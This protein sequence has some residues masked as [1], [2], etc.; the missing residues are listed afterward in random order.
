[1]VT[2][3]ISRR[4]ALKRVGFLMGGAL[5]APAV[6]GFLGGCRTGAEAEW[7][8]AVLTGRH[9]DLTAAVADRIIPETDTPGAGH[10]EVQQFIDRML[11][12]WYPDDLRRRF[13]DGL[14][15]LDVRAQDAAG[16]SF[17][18]ADAD[19]QHEILAQLDRETF[20]AADRAPDTGSIRER[21]EGGTVL[22]E[23]VDLTSET[24]GRLQR[25]I[26]EAAARTTA[27]RPDGGPVVRADTAHEGSLIGDPS[28]WR[29]MKELTLLGYYWSE[30]GATQELNYVQVPGKWDACIP[31][32]EVGKTW[33]TG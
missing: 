17:L 19:R 27:R 8:P 1:M 6:A 22:K 24:R 7:Q 2:H 26:D 15:D 11:S 30:P 16:T 33:A 31:F 10:V 13:I 5:S 29:I 14:D 32:A 25:S 4:E 18:E 28:F 21:I 3:S 12:E 23:T 20:A 9:G